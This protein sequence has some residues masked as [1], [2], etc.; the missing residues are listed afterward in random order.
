MRQFA[1]E[2]F[3]PDANCQA[4][5]LGIVRELP[6][7]ETQGARQG[8]KGLQGFGEQFRID[9]A[10]QDLLNHFAGFDWAKDRAQ[11]RGLGYVL[12][13]IR[14]GSVGERIEVT[15]WPAGSRRSLL[16]ILV[17]IP[18]PARDQQRTLMADDIF[19]IKPGVGWFKVN[20]RA[21]WRRF[22]TSGRCGPVTIVAERFLALFADHGIAPAQIQQFLPELTLDKLNSTDALLPALTNSVLDQAAALFK[23]RRE[24]LDGVGDRIYDCKFC[25]KS[26]QRFFE[27][28]ADL[29][30]EG[31]AFPVRALYGGKQLDGSGDRCQPLVLLLVEKLRDLGEEE[32]FRYIIFNDRWDWGH[33]PCRVQLKTMARMM[34][35]VLGKIVPLYR[36]DPAILERVHGGK[37]IP[38][39]CLRGS[40]LTNPSLEDY[41]LSAEES[42]VAKE[43]EELPAVL[44]YIN[45]HALEALALVQN[46][47]ER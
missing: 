13:R 35:R 32:I 14:G 36:V 8:R 17:A 4:D 28:L 7:T 12:A 5:G 20:L 43:C 23:I 1:Q 16:E 37:C 40:P 6:T 25:Y 27:A 3:L 38:Q 44:K 9:S 46:R 45:V 30:N 2:R 19:E 24:W 10:P 42:T 41:A 21:L 39:Q 34:D 26:P 11:R 33:A 29:K 47:G 15:T 18:L 22:A 31:H